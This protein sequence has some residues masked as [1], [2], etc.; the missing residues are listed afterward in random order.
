MYLSDKAAKA[1]RNMTGT[2]MLAIVAVLIWFAMGMYSGYHLKLLLHPQPK[3]V[4][5]CVSV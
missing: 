3:E 5:Q 2:T 1:G 4:S